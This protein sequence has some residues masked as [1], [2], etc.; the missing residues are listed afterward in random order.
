MLDVFHM[1]GVNI[2]NVGCF[3]LCIN[4]VVEP[5]LFFLNL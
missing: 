5:M 1:L 3:N 2:W 4:R